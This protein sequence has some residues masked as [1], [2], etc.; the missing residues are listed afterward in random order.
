[1]PRQIHP[2]DV[3]AYW[4]VGTV[5]LLGTVHS[6]GYETEVLA[7]N[8]AMLESVDRNVREAWIRPVFHGGF[9]GQPVQ[10]YRGGKAVS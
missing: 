1:M 3:V 7:R 4:R 9:I 5:S 2:E 6:E 8:A 10:Y